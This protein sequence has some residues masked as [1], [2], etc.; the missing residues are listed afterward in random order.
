MNSGYKNIEK[1]LK[2][3][4]N[5]IYWNWLLYKILSELVTE[6]NLQYQIE[7]QPQK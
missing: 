7:R 5:F 4:E 6:C 2:P 3:S 1:T